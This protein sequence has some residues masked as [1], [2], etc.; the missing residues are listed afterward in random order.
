MNDRIEW[1][2]A[3][4]FNSPWLTTLVV[5]F[6][7]MSLVLLREDRALTGS[8]KGYSSSCDFCS[9]SWSAWAS[10]VQD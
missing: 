5:V 7:V 4:I 3:P 8:Q 10:I 1:T 6:L 9:L 2:W